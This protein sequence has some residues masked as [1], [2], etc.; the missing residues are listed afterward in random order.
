M[1]KVNLT[2]FTLSYV[3]KWNNENQINHAIMTK[4]TL[5]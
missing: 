2:I 5:R 1:T 4:L 3:L